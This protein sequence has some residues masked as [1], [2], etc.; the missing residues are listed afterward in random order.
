MALT[1]YLSATLRSHVPGYDP[2]KGV[3]VVLQEETTVAEL[4][5]HLNIPV[6]QVKIVMVNGKHGTL[7]HRLNRDDRVALF[8]PVGG[9]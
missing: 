9:G 1:L 2:Q 3:H 5:R 4:C 7:T 8:P 6:E